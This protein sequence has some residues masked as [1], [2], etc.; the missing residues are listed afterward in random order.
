VVQFLVENNSQVAC[1]CI[2]LLARGVNAHWGLF[3][4]NCIHAQPASV[5]ITPLSYLRARLAGNMYTELEGWVMKASW[6]ICV[7]HRLLGTSIRWC[8]GQR[9]VS[10]EYTIFAALP[11]QVFF[12]LLCCCCVAF[13]AGGL[14]Q[15][16]R[17]RP[18]GSAVC[19]N[20]VGCLALPKQ[21][22]FVLLCC[23]RWTSLAA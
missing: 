14:P 15:Q 10:R 17:R 12:V 11:E 5:V 6:G 3:I 23:C 2:T 7:V 9:C 4:G 16:P 19:L 21:L 20:H 18:G 1:A 13:T 22:Y 8:R